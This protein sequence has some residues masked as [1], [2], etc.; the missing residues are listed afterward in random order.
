MNG[1]EGDMRFNIM[2]HPQRM[3][4]FT[5]EIQQLDDDLD[6]KKRLQTFFAFALACYVI[7]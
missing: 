5:Y 4:T 6:K 1:Y 2:T 3:R 7:N